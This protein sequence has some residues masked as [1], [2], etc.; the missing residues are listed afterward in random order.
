MLEM[1]SKDRKWPH[2]PFPRV[3][4]RALHR[5]LRKL[6]ARVPNRVPRRPVH[7]SFDAERHAG[8][9][10]DR[11]MKLNTANLRNLAYDASVAGNMAEAAR[12]YKAAADAYPVRKGALAKADI[13]RLERYAEC[14]R[15]SAE[16]EASKK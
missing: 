15:L 2:G 13:A 3:P 9:L 8:D 5:D 11:D 6:A 12:L 4:V 14:H 1:R 7:A 10:E 16:H